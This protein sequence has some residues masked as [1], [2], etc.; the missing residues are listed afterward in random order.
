MVGLRLF[1]VLGFDCR[2]CGCCGCDCLLLRFGCFDLYCG[3][4]LGPIGLFDMVCFCVF[5]LCFLFCVCGWIW[6]VILCGA[7]VCG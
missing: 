7:W 6:L 3:F 1:V 2:F 5:L 4:W